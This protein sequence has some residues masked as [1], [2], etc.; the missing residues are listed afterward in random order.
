MPPVVHL[1]R[2]AQAEHNVDPSPETYKK[3]RDPVLTELGR[4]QAT[5]LRNSFTQIPDLMVVSPL[6]RTL[7]TALLGLIGPD[8]PVVLNA[9]VQETAGWPCDTGSDIDVLKESFADTNLDFDRL[10]VDWNSKE[11]LWAP[12]ED[13]LTAR[14]T[15]VRKWLRDRSEKEIVVVTH[16]GFLHRLTQDHVGFQN[17]EWRTYTFATDGQHDD[18]ARFV[19]VDDGGE[20]DKSRI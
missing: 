9:D 11:G 13:A 12:T 6:R 16:A 2:H 10:P 1:L 4:S 14:A 20:I 8:I 18:E 19:K 5:A 3:Y 17:T 7:Q 15:R